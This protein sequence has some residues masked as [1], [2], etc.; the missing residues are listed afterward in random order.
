MESPAIDNSGGSESLSEHELSRRAFMERSIKAIMAFMTVSL[1]IPALGYLISP[2]LQQQESQWVKLGRAT[3]VKPG[4]P[5][6]FRVTLKQTTGWV[7]TETQF[8]YFV[9]T[10]D[11]TNF[12]VM[13]NICTHLGCQTHWNEV[14]GYIECPCHGGRFDVEGNVIGGPVPRPLKRVEFKVDDKGNILSREV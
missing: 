7:Q 11:G 4:V 8:A 6:L 14:D 12:S 3:E 1:G 2:A 10:R 9:Y 13:S 5:T